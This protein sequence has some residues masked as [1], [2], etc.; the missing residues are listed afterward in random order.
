MDKFG[1]H[2]IHSQKCTSCSKSVT[3]KPISGCIWIA[4]LGLMTTSLLQVVNRLA[5]SCKLH[6]G[7][8]RVVSS[9]C[10]KSA[11]IKLQQV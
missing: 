10:T 9:T 4:S 5:A 1:I 8:M 11:N 2:A 6:A 7:L 3:T